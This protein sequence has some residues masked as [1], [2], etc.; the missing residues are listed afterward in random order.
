MS[1]KRQLAILIFVVFLIGFAG[2]FLAAAIT[3]YGDVYVD[4][5]QA[6][7][8][9]NGTLEE[10]FIY[11]IEESGKYRMLYRVWEAPLSWE[12]RGEPYVEPVS[13]S[14]PPGTIPYTKDWRGQVKLLST[15]QT[16]YTDDIR[17]LALRNEVGC[18][19]PEKFE[20][21]EYK[22]GYVFIVHPPLEWD[23]EYVHVNLKLAH[24]HLPY[25]QLTIAIHDP[26]GF[27]TRLFTHPPMEVRKDGSIWVITGESPKDTLLELEMLLKPEIVD[28]MD[29]FSREVSDVEGETRSANLRYYILYSFFSALR[30]ILTALI[31]L[32]P[33]LLGLVYYKQG[34][35]RQFT[36]P[37]FLSYVPQSRKPWLVNLVF[38]G[39]A[40]DFD[41]H[42]FYAT[43]LDLQRQG[44]LKIET[45]GEAAGSLRIELLKGPDAGIDDYEQSVLSF[46]RDHAENGV[47]D[48]KVFEEK[49]EKLRD[50]ARMGEYAMLSLSGIHDRMKGLL[51][52]ADKSV[53][54]EFVLGGR[55][56]VAKLII[57]FPLTLLAM[58]LLFFNFRDAY[59]QLQTC[60]V[61]SFI[62]SMQSIPPIVAPTALFGRWKRDYYK[63]KLEW[64]AFKTFL[65]DFASIRK[66]APEDVTMWKEWLVYGTAL[67]VGDKVAK[68]ME[69]L[70]VSIP[71]ADADAAIYMP[72]YFGHAF[73]LT[74]PV[75][76]G[77]G[78]GGIGG[79]GGFG[80]GG[81]FGGG[82]GGAR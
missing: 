66:Y 61:S 71:D 3:C 49:V 2:V 67:G 80:A 73:R 81:G 62:L 46:L 20:A 14:P 35:E 44:I 1:E 57:P 52:V 31:F 34:R 79:G 21:G 30:S 36:V 64:D 18:Y 7:L 11:E 41:E 58:I 12:K 47:F 70:Q 17:S 13:I 29:G 75:A 77:T 15:T 60:L 32:F 39:D 5:Y 53:A 78:V 6:D 33:V 8:Y 54:E 45:E 74:T 51:H 56:Q 28:G 27:V 10:T 65:S 38:K 82:G 26:N 37:K 4:S 16:A 22:I 25:K 63:E 19:K 9:P 68:A 48:T 50:S 76:T 72:L 42:G 59:P 43:L 55:K 23:D 69:K 40:F 24:E